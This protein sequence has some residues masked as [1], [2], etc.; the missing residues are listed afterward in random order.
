MTI[1]REKGWR[2]IGWCIR[3]L[4]TLSVSS[5]LKEVH[6][7]QPGR[8]WYSSDPRPTA[9]AAMSLAGKS[10]A[11][12]IADLA[13]DLMEQDRP[14]EAAGWKIE[15]FGDV[16]KGQ[17]HFNMTRPGAPGCWQVCV[18]FEREVSEQGE[19]KRAA[20]DAENAK[21]DPRELVLRL[22]NDEETEE[23]AFRAKEGNFRAPRRGDEFSV[24]SATALRSF[25]DV[26]PGPPARI[27]N[28]NCTDA[29]GPFDPDEIY[30]PGIALTAHAPLTWD[31]RAINASGDLGRSDVFLGPE[32]LC[33]LSTV[34]QELGKEAQV[35]EAMEKYVKQGF[36]SSCTG[37]AILLEE[38]GLSAVRE[39]KGFLD[40]SVMEVLATVS[41]IAAEKSV[42]SVMEDYRTLITRLPALG[43]DHAE[44]Q[45]DCNDM[46]DF[47]H[48]TR[49]G[50]IATLHLRTENGEYRL[51]H[52]ED[53]GTFLVHD[54]AREQGL[55]SFEV[56]QDENGT[57]NAKILSA[58]DEYSSRTVTSFNDAVRITSSASCCLEEDHPI[59][60]EGLSP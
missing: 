8:L 12:A 26:P 44:T 28:F 10:M 42:A 43:F 53:S 31:D 4:E 36:W 51:V 45:Y 58:S 59:E 33:V 32:V 47:L 24:I 16:S 15:W 21:M 41:A 25:P 14:I 48:V 49:D 20:L 23:T 57:W 30:W 13:M 40:N 6:A 19:I 9:E 22:L 55:G 17:V 18:G 52:D 7:E 11:P 60:E 2:D 37:R 39:A 27:S 35:S 34:L 56:E 54:C 5:C 1:E 3:P 50:D 46:D 38:L 29:Q